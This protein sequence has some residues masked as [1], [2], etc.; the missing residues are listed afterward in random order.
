MMENKFSGIYISYSELLRDSDEAIASLP[1]NAELD[2]IYR[3]SK[4][5][6]ELDRENLRYCTTT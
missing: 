1:S 4:L 3:V 5:V 6:E 2:E